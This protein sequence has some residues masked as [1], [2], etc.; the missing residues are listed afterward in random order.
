MELKRKNNRIIKMTQGNLQ[1]RSETFNFVKALNKF[2]TKQKEIDS[3]EYVR[4]EKSKFL[5]GHN[6]VHIRQIDFLLVTYVCSTVEIGLFK[7]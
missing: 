1:K 3:C 6:A 5:L 2:L 7:K 4:F